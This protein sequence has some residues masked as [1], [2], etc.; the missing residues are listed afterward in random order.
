MMKNSKYDEHLRPASKRPE[1]RRKE[2][3]LECI[4]SAILDVLL[5][6]AAL[7]F[8]ALFLTSGESGRWL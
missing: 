5:I 4:A 8:I 6:L 2:S 7:F 3:K 1:L